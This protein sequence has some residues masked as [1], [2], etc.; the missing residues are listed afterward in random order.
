MPDLLSQK[1]DAV[2]FEDPQPGSLDDAIHEDTPA[3]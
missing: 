3:E 2:A 1:H